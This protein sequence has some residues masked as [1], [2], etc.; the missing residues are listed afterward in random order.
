VEEQTLSLPPGQ[1]ERKEPMSQEAHSRNAAQKVLPG[2]SIRDTQGNLGQKDL[3]LPKVKALR[4][5]RQG[6]V[7][8]I[9]VEKGALFKKDLEIP[10]D[11]V[12]YVEEQPAQGQVTIHVRAKELQ[13]FS[14]RE[15]Q[16]LASQQQAEREARQEHEQ[17]EHQSTSLWVWLRQLGPGLLGGL[18]GNDSSAVT[19]YAIDGARVGFGHLWLLLLST[20]M[21]QAV[22]YACAKIGRVTGQGFGAVVCEHYGRPWAV[23]VAL[24]L[25]VANVALIAANLVAMGSG[26]MLLVGL[27]WVWFVVPV[28]V[29]L[30]YLV[31]YSHFELM[32]KIFLVMSLAFLA[33]PITAILARPNWSAILLATV[34]PHLDFRLDSITS[35]VALLGAT[36]SPYTMFWQVQGETEVQR[37]GP[38]RRQVRL[39]TLDITSGAISGNVI[40]YFMIVST[41][42]TLSTHH[43]RITTAADAAAALVPLVGPFATYLFALGLIG[44]GA[45]AIPV[46]LAS[47]AYAITGTIGWPAGLSK[48]PWENE[49]FYLI[50]SGALLV[51]LVLALLHFNPIQLI[52]WANVLNGLLAPVL[53]AFL[54]LIANNRAIMD[55]HHVGLLTN[56][57]L[58]LSMLV[59]LVAAVLLVYGLLTGPSGS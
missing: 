9:I 35:A 44:A 42:A 38:M 20:P 4:R 55:K 47:T 40:A 34:V 7:E 36:L 16:K 11:R 14:A 31:T 10:A 49:G 50:L 3:S 37:P 30:W 24:V 43:Q 33:Y 18:S 54:F 45:V 52:L 5:N 23:L 21:Y 25:V 22:L 58:V 12:L 56:A 57:W 13:A 53:I 26:F 1:Q 19:A 39:M 51:S 2:M 41:A 59:L 8:T 32:K 48:L 46:L 6:A 17:A 15:P 28:A 27:T 29:L